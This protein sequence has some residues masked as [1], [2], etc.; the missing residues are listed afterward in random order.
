MQQRTFK[1][2]TSTTAIL[3]E[4]DQRVIVTIPANAVVTLMVGDPDGDGFVKV[5]YRDHVLS[6]FAID[7]RTRGERMW[8]QS[9]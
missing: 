4:N 8:G 6:V 5:R 1:L 2:S 3:S 7:L 9:A